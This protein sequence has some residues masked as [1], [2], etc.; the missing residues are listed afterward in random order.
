MKEKCPVC[1]HL[2]VDH[3]SLGCFWDCGCNMTNQEVKEELYKLKLA[4]DKPETK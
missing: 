3:T 1:Q 2:V 4:L